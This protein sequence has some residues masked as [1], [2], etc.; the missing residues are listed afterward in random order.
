MFLIHHLGTLGVSENSLREELHLKEGWLETLPDEKLQSLVPEL[1]QAAVALTGEEHICLQAGERFHFCLA[2]VGGL[3]ATHAPTPGLALETF[4]RFVGGHD[5]IRIKK[6]VAPKETS[7]YPEVLADWPNETRQQILD[8]F[9]A[10][11]VAA[12]RTVCGS[13][14]APREIRLARPRPLDT[15]PFERALRG[16]VSFNAVRDE[17][18]L[19]TEKLSMPSELYEPMLFEQL[20]FIAD[21]RTDLP[22]SPS[23]MRM[24]V[25]QAIRAGNHSIERVAK[26]LQVKTRTLQ[27]R[28]QTEGVTFRTVLNEIRVSQAED[29]L[30]NTTLPLAEIAKRLNYSDEKGLRKAIKHVTGK[31]PSQIRSESASL[32][33]S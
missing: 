11:L 25:E 28:L 33:N 13:S 7:L 16:K 19:L 6:S 18:I 3:V 26:T 20:R 31:V 22:S 2:G 15:K 23:P 4:G 12:L 30:L 21:L 1:I 32:P 24:L 14:F 8:G 10:S 29:L 17:V 5:L 9:C 27:R